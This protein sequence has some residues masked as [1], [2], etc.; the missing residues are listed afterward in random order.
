MN[1]AGALRSA[2]SSTRLQER[3]PL[4]AYRRPLLGTGFCGALTTFSTMQVELLGWSTPTATASRPATRRRASSLGYARV[5]LATA[6]VAPDEGAR[7]SLARWVGVAVLGGVGR[8]RCASS[9]DGPCR[10]RGGRAFPFG[11][12]AVNLSG[13]VALGLRRRRS[14]STGDALVLAGTATI[15]SYTTF[16]T[17]MLE[18]QRLDRGRGG[19]RRARRTSLVSVALGLGARR[20]RARASGAHL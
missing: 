13:A 6:L 1:I 4:S 2:T 12:L 19:S 8:A 3:L 11:T 5:H 9:L 20:A 15:G 18:T 7:V 16:S 10:A 17:W 14:R